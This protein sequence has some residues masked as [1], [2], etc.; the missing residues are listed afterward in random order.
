MH[1]WGVSGSLFYPILK[2]MLQNFKE[3]LPVVRML[4]FVF[5]ESFYQGG[6]DG[7]A[8]LMHMWGP[9]CY[10]AYASEF[11]ANVFSGN[12]VIVFTKGD[13]SLI[14]YKNI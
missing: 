1:M 5:S 10:E 11:Q 8:S 12:N 6:S 13:R 9:P 3:M 14:N 2:R 7:S 4:T